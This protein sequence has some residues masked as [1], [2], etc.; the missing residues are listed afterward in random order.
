M[1]SRFLT[2]VSLL[3]VGFPAYAGEENKVEV[4]A[5]RPVES[6][7]YKLG[8]PIWIA[9]VYGQTGVRGKTVDVSVG[10]NKILGHLNFV[11]SFVAEARK[12]PLGIYADFL[13]LDDRAGTNPSGVV[14]ATALQ[15]TEY[16]VDA[17]ASWR[18]IER[19]WG[20]VD[21]RAGCRYTN[22]YDRLGLSP[23][24]RE[25]EKASV[26]LADTTVVAVRD[27]LRHDLRVLEGKAPPLPLPPLAADLNKKLLEQILK[28]KQNPALAVALRSRS[29][30]LVAQAKRTL[31]EKIAGILH[32][33]LSRNYPLENYWFDPYVGLAGRYNLSPAAYLMA[34]ADVGGFGLG[35]QLT[36]Q[37]YG[38]VGYQFTRRIYGEAGYRALY[39][40]YRRAGFVYDVYTKG[41]QITVGVTF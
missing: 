34:R 21:A 10:P 27:L 33:A 24:N 25:I 40:D 6:W 38:A 29:P 11:S 7:E 16:L 13:Y 17:E 9:G 31:Q 2:L 5:V 8:V 36:W 3:A 39:V 30:E 23:D 19:S 20:W 37:A 15:V 28:A 26:Q 4:R 41:A 22:L 12:G 1:K 18:L 32:K 14:A 35:S